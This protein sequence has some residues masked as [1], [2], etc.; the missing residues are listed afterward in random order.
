[1]LPVS[2]HST[3][4]SISVEQLKQNSSVDK[5]EPTKAEILALSTHRQWQKLLH[6]E[7]GESEIE[8]AD[9]FLSHEHTSDDF[10]LTELNKTL[11]LIKENPIHENGFSFRC[12]YPARV[13]FLAKYG[14]TNPITP[15]ECPAVFDWLGGEDFGIS[16]V[17]ADGYLGNPASFY[18]HLIF[19]FESDD[20]REDL[21]SNSLNFG[22]RVP[23]NENPV[24]YIIKGLFGGYSARYTSNFFFRHSINY[25]EVEL[26]DLY[27][28]KLTLSDYNRLLLAFHTW[29]L[30][31]TSY[32]YYFTH[33]NCAYHVGK[34]LELVSDQDLISSRHPFVLPI[35]IFK[36]AINATSDAKPIVS[37]IGYIPS[38]QTRM[39]EEIFKLN[40][41]Q[42]KVIEE[43]FT[44]VLFGK[45][46]ASAA[47][48]KASLQSLLAVLT[49]SEQTQVLEA[50]LAYLEFA[51][52][53]SDDNEKKALQIVKRNIQR[54]R[55]ALP[56]SKKSTQSQPKLPSIL[57]HT[58]HHPSLLRVTAGSANSD[59]FTE[60]TLRPAFY[61]LY[62]SGGGILKNSALTMGKVSIRHTQNKFELSGIDLLHI[63]TYPTGGTGLPF[64]KD[65]AWKLRVGIERDYIDKSSHKLEWFADAGVGKAFSVN[66]STLFYS[67]LNGRLQ[68]PD[69]LSNRL[70]VKPTVG[71]ITEFGPTRGGC[72]IAYK[73]SIASDKNTQR[74][75]IKCEASMF[76]QASWDLR[77]T[78]ETYFEE[79]FGVGLSW[80]W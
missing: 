50:G 62:A 43:I 20:P 14:Y 6:I 52:T 37:D 18:G 79:S 2:A 34:S 51:S 48:D 60:I 73:A 4:A 12:R 11:A 36:S 39:R 8:N 74:R 24:V 44:T 31:N 54:L 9:F 63:E 35:A 57:P 3:P 59:S 58:G 64:D 42:Q 55:I 46:N 17:Y 1:M 65:M 75:R 10:A 25:N 66:D 32:T 53:Q 28:Y 30:N 71:F 38:R 40:E 78:Y 80:Y 16:L 70:F 72:E 47:A 56:A 67:M 15:K 29:E 19:K 33:R 23:E 61:D 69:S 27:K 7:H 76:Q 41:Q 13:H 49:P 68:T 77:L 21:F 26:R 22:A 5:Q 45:T